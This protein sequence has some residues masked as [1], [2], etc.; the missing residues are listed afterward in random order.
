MA[1][2]G[3][4]PRRRPVLIAAGIAAAIAALI[5]VLALVLLGGGGATRKLPPAPTLP[6]STSTIATPTQPPAGPPAKLAPTHEQLGI[7]VNRLF[8]DRTFTPAQIDASLAALRRTGATL[9]RSDALWEAGE[10]TAP[11]AG[12][13][14]YDWSFDDEI[15]GSLAAHGLQ[16]LPILD[17]S[18]P[19]AQ[20]IPGQDH[21]APRP[22]SDFALWAG[23]VAA[24]YGAGGTFWRQHPALRAPPVDTYE[25]WNEPDN[26]T[27]WVPAPNA[28]YYANLY[29]QTRDA[30]AA[31]DP[32]AR[33]LVGGLT[34]PRAFLPAMLH[35]RPDLVGHVDGVAIHPY[36]ANPLVALRNVEVARSV[37][38]SLGLSAVPMYVTEVG[39]TTRPAGALDWAPAQARP[40]Y[41]SATLAT[42]GHTNCGLAAALLYTWVTPERNPKNP[43]D[44]FGIEPP[45]GGG[46]PDVSAFTTGVE[47]AAAP[48]PTVRLCAG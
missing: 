42:L 11:T 20:S 21:S 27:F 38:D 32:G 6:A 29:L 47:K 18:A 26:P 30:I 2:E 34:N 33:V 41:I 35:A 4:E 8:N 13:H 16:W 24:R 19:W 5:A 14:H 15:A 3:D 23:A 25:V 12:V 31:A 45:G 17:Y 43:Q 28:A 40:G 39:W 36:G 1:P 22:A 44:W 10:P 9:A 7:N 48:A 37:L 46:G